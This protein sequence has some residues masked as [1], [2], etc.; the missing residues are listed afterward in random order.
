MSEPTRTTGN[1]SPWAGVKTIEEKLPYAEPSSLQIAFRLELIAAYNDVWS[2][3]AGK[4]PLN[5]YQISCIFGEIIGDGLR[6]NGTAGNKRVLETL[7]KYFMA[8]VEAASMSE[9]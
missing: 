3:F 8:A 2:R 1:V 5:Y 9:L 4:G 7:K 6:T